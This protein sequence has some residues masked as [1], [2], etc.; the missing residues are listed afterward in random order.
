MPEATRRLHLLE[1][2]DPQATPLTLAH[3][4]H[5]AG[6][7]GDAVLIAAGPTLPLEPV[8]ECLGRDTSGVYALGTPDGRAWKALPALHR[9]AALANRAHGPF[10]QLVLWS[11]NMLG[12]PVTR[13]WVQRLAAGKLKVVVTHQSDDQHT[14]AWLKRLPRHAALGAVTD[15]LVEWVTRCGGHAVETVSAFAPGRGHGD[16]QGTGSGTPSGPRRVLLVADPPARVSGMD[17]MLA[18][19]LADEMLRP[20]GVRVNLIMPPG[21]DG[22]TEV[23]HTSRALGQADRVVVEPAAA[24]PWRVLGDC[25]AALVLNSGAACS[26]NAITCALRSGKPTVAAESPVARTLIDNGVT[27]LIGAAGKPQRLAHRLVELLGD[28]ALAARVG[29]AGQRAAEAWCGGQTVAAV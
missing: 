23:H 29:Q 21:V 20:H 13:W 6:Q 8:R 18:V 24:W 15:A 11:P 5:E 19:G 12:Q 10:S 27:G 22:A 4:A 2:A 9:A 16:K 28:E 3:L 26:P 7:H 25:D 17:A 14:R 1:A